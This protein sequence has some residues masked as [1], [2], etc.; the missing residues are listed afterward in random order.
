[1]TTMAQSPIR[2]VRTFAH[3]RDLRLFGDRSFVANCRDAWA[4]AGHHNPVPTILAMV[5]QAIKERPDG[6][7]LLDVLISALEDRYRAL[8][9]DGQ[10]EEETQ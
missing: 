4:V 3:Y 5:D 9:S 1:M 6:T 2:I 10:Q 7:H 8:S